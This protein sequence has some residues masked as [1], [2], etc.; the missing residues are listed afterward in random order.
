MHKP[1]TRTVRFVSTNGT[2]AAEVTRLGLGNHGAALTLFMNGEPVYRE[3]HWDADFRWML[4]Q[5]H[6][7]LGKG[8]RR[9]TP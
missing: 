3:C 2:V 1:I 4:A 8:A 7:L 5:T 6:R 9:L